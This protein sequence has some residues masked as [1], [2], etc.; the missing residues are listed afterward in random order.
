MEKDEWNIIDHY[1]SIFTVYFVLEIANPPW[2][3]I[4]SLVGENVNA[5]EFFFKKVEILLIAK[6]VRFYSRVTPFDTFVAPP[7]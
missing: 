4:G 1:Y 6:T 5:F 3:E 2:G 7:G